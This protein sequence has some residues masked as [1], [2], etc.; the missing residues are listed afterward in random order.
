MF[1]PRPWEVNNYLFRVGL[2]AARIF[3]VKTIHIDEPNF[4]FVDNMI[5][6]QRGYQMAQRDGYLKLLTQNTIT[7]PVCMKLHDIPTGFLETEAHSW[8]STTKISY[9]YI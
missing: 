6:A 8:T 2:Y 5:N 3:F 4:I 7:I 9:H 1:S